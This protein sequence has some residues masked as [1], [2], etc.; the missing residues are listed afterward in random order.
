MALAAGACTLDKQGEPANLIG[1][2]GLS[3]A[4]GVTASPDILPRDGASEST[5][6]VTARDAS[7]NPLAGKTVRLS[8]TAG[9][10]SSNEVTT[11][12]NGQATTMFKAP[13]LNPAI[14]SVNI[15]ATPIGG[16]FD[17]L[18]S[19][20]I[21][22]SLTT[23]TAAPV[24]GFSFSPDDPGQFDLVSFNASSTTYG[25]VRCG[26]ACTYRWTFGDGTSTEGLTTTHRYNSPG[27]FLVT[28]VVTAPGGV[29]AET[30]QD[31]TVGVATLPTPLI[32]FSPTEPLVG[33]K[34]QF[35]GRG[36]TTPDGSAIEKYEWDFGDTFG[37]A[38]T[39]GGS[40][41]EHT[42]SFARSYTVRLTVTD[43]QGRTATTTE[44]VEVSEVGP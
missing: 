13:A 25:G 43:S 10:L 41:A 30:S 3:E 39:A 28:L 32:T 7:G 11:D 44:E 34:V 27:T 38:N 20:T 4:F 40:T 26:T 12:G 36:S 24:A 18:R 15:T 14:Q 35:D 29:E 31:V 23:S 2:A 21:S 1:P 17:P 42:F 8:S 22:I 37:V 6:R 16:D 33:D 19:Q 9:Q 5:I